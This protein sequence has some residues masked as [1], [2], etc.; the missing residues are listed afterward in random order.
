MIE[1]FIP[2]IAL[3]LSYLGSK[4][5]ASALAKRGLTV[6]DMHK[7]GTPQVPRPGGPAI[8]F[9]IVVA[10]DILYVVTGSEE[11]LA[12]SLTVIIAFAVGVYDDIRS[13]KGPV[14]VALLFTASLPILLLHTYVPLPPFPFA[15]HLRITTI[16]PILVF[17]AIPVTSNAFNMID[18]YNGLISGFSAIATLPLFVSFLIRGDMLMVSISLIFMMTMLGFYLLHR[19]PSKLFPGDSGSLAIGAAYGAIAIIGRVEIVAVVALLPAILNA[20]FVISSV[21]GIIEH[22][23]MKKRPVR[24]NSDFT[25][26]ASRE[27][28]AP[29]TLARMLLSDGNL[30]EKEVVYRFFVLE[31]FASL[32]AIITFLLTEVRL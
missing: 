31:A 26:V 15:G 21:G 9:A 19:N 23:E 10:L 3:L 22:K 29:V 7:P 32:L 27:S 30:S 16:Y 14:K 5:L 25:L 2:I 28:D 24:L 18:I 17:L 4:Y 1:L 13:L 20:F 8:A 12:L 6:P 11:V